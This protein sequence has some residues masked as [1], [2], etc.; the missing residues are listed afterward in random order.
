MEWPDK[1]MDT[2]LSQ[3]HMR[4]LHLEDN[5][6]DHELVVATLAG[7]RWNITATRD[8]RDTASRPLPD[9]SQS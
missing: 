9:V 2:E 4:V 3:R 8:Q 7:R 5:T 1:L 6:H